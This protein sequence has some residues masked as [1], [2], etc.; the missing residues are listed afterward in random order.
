MNQPAMKE[1]RIYVGVSY[2]GAAVMMRVMIPVDREVCK[3]CAGAG[4]IYETD[5]ECGACKGLGTVECRE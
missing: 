3:P 5:E 2:D 1:A 4:T